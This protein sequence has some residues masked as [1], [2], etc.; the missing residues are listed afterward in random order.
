MKE[1]IKLGIILLIITSIA[2]AGLGYVNG[3]TEGPIAEQTRLADIEARKQVLPEAE[4]FQPLDIESPDDY[5]IVSEVFKG[6]V[7][8]KDAGYTFKTVPGGYGGVIEVMIGISSDG[9]ITGVSI[10]NHSETPGLGAKASD[11]AY[12]GQYVG[13]TSEKEV[14]VI[15]V[16]EPSGNEVVAISGA[17]ITSKAV[18][19]GV[20]EAIKYFNEKLK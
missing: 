2:A 15:K 6:T 8:G 14:D 5:K 3:I 11:E 19:D 10:G 9:S 4:D 7:E 18:T 13:K 17:T 1:I 16:G 20:N 12:E